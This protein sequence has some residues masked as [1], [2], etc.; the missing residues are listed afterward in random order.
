MPHILYIRTQLEFDV[1]R[2]H[3]MFGN[4]VVVGVIGVVIRGGSGS[5]YGNDALVLYLFFHIQIV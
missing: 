5:G 4:V 2:V 3:K 1:Y